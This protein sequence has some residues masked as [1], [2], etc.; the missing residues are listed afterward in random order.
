MDLKRKRHM[1][2]VSAF[3][4]EFSYLRLNHCFSKAQGISLSEVGVLKQICYFE[5]EHYQP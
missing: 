5:I 2:A 4:S 3:E 1:G